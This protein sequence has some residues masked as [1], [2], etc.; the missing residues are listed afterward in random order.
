[1]QI[2]VKVAN[3]QERSLRIVVD[4]GSCRSAVLARSAGSKEYLKPCLMV[5]LGGESKEFI[6]FPLPPV[7]SQTP[8]EKMVKI[9][10]PQVG[11][12]FMAQE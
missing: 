11:L 5:E 7:I 10:L 4:K 3:T 9:P 8:K 1:M 6:S 2:L 12:S